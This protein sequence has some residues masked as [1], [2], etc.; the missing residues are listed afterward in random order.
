MTEF[1]TRQQL[2]ARTNYIITAAD[3]VDG[4]WNVTVKNTVDGKI[5]TDSSLKVYNVGNSYDVYGRTAGLYELKDDEG[6]VT[7]A[8]VPDRSTLLYILG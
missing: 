5:N 2:I 4:S 6:N 3:F 8:A 1:K 7:L